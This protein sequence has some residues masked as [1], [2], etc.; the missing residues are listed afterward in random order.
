MADKKSEKYDQKIDV[1]DLDEVSGGA[2]G[3]RMIATMW[4][5]R[6]YGSSGT[7]GQVIDTSN[8]SNEGS[9][10]SVMANFCAKAGI[11]YQMNAE[12]MDQ[13]KIDGQWRDA[14]WLADN[15]QYAL[16]YFDKKLGLK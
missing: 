12:G 7:H 15:K 9:V 1:A 5:A 6:Y 8:I 11:D 14:M 13:F 16:D 4:V 2:I 3:D 10:N